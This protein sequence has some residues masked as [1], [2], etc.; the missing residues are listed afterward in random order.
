MSEV[1][2]RSVE[3][4]LGFQ[5]HH[6]T[7]VGA[8]L[9]LDRIAV[10]VDKFAKGGRIGAIEL[11]QLLGALHAEPVGGRIVALH[12]ALDGVVE[13]AMARRISGEKHRGHTGL[14]FTAY[15]CLSQREQLRHAA[16]A[17]VVSENGPVAPSE[18]RFQAREIIGGGRYCASRIE[19][20]I[21][22]CDGVRDPVADDT[23]NRRTGLAAHQLPL[24]DD[25]ESRHAN[26]P[27]TGGSRGGFGELHN[28]FWSGRTFGVLVAPAFQVRDGGDQRCRQPAGRGGAAKDRCEARPGDPNGAGRGLR[29]AH[30]HEGLRLNHAPGASLQHVRR[31]FGTIH[32]DARETIGGSEVLGSSEQNYRG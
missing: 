28:A 7:I 1:V 21:A 5:P 6:K 20:I 30:D 17:T 11:Q 26:H 4:V 22:Y 25:L 8:T 19:A 23:V 31:Y 10:L 18:F 3:H 13:V 16:L 29:F 14:L 15:R 32:T 24:G 12:V 27:Q 2:Q 9:G